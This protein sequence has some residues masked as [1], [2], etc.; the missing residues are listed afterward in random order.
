M[1]P[2]PAAE[3]PVSVWM[4]HLERAH[5]RAHAAARAIEDHAEPS[6]HLA[7][8]AR[9]LE[10]GLAAMYDAFDGRADRVTAIGVAHACLW[11][12]AILM[13]RAG[14]SSALAALREACAEL[15]SAE[16]RFPRV[17]LAGR[18]AVE[19][20]AGTYLPPLHTIER[21][22]LVPSFRAPLVPKPEEEAAVVELP[23]PTTF[24]ELAAVAEAARH[25]ARERA[26]ALAE[27]RR[28]LPEAK[29]QAPAPV[30]VPS[31]FAFVPPPP[32]DEDAFVR[33]WARECFD[34]IGMLG[35]QRTPL[36]GDDWRAC[37][38][39]ETRLITAIDALAALGP[40]GIASV[41]PLAMDTPVANPMS[42]FA[43]AMIGG[44]L[45]GRDAL[46]CAERVLYRFGPNDP[47]VAE[48]FASAMK[49]AP[50]PLVRIAMRSLY[51]SAE[52]GGRAIAVEVL[53]YRG[54]LTP[55]ELAELADEENPRVLALALSA[56]AV[57][58]HPD[59]GRALSRALAHADLR[60]QAAA[61]D[62]M[63]LGAHPQAASAARTAA[64]GALGE[65]ALIRLA[66]VAG[67]D[68]ARWLIERME[69]SPTPAAIEAVGWAGLVDA[70]PVLLR[71][72]ESDAPKIKLATGAALDRLLGAHLIESIKVL[73]EAL[74]TVDVVDPDSEP[75]RPREP[76]EVLVSDPRD[77][78]PAGSS[79]TLE[80]PSTDPAKW[81]AYWAEHGRHH[82][83]KLRLRRG[84]AYSPS[85]SLYE[86]DQLPLSPEDRRR[87]HHELAAR[88]G[89]AARFDP[90]D[91]V[92]TQEQSIK[93]WE[94]LVRASAER[95]GS[96]GRAMIR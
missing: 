29:V 3:D 49:L 4:T 92:P 39:L 32:L 61:L 9:R 17:Q 65:R 77:R 86:L 80:V 59:F 69:A 70:V 19:L 43:M 12:A 75:G 21:A 79:E 48:P 68:D 45:E 47:T 2:E 8:A 91:F 10:H 16:E 93:D 44:C 82:D 38:V 24:E 74:E 7:P 50:S 96:W 63:A 14:L 28:E 5:D 26:Q 66:I 27:R 25:F 60:L 13:A 62:A 58:R 37:Q 54:W 1:H 41:E 34:E 67:V 76:I 71:L 40:I 53:A 18:V 11:D 23:E 55:S 94:S 33:R 87:L 51:A 57:A 95:P 31:G 84:Q 22:S 52:L 46:A 73:P 81:R 36:A 30:D 78:P 64:R 56:L 72:L 88:T 42:V 20:Q 89:K 15:V 83:P 90:Y 85:I 6:A 35:L